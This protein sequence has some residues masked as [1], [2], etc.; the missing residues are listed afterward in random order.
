M[1]LIND[2]EPEFLPQKKNQRLVSKLGYCGNY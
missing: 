1:L 2:A